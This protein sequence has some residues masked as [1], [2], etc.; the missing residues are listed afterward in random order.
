LGNFGEGKG[1]STLSICTVCQDE[2]EPIRWYLECCKRLY[3]DLGDSL[4]EVVLVDGGSKDNTIDVIN[5]YK[6]TIPIK[7]LERPWDYTVAQTNYGLSFCTGDFTFL[8]DADMTWTSNFADV[9]KSGK[10]S[11]SPYWDFRLL[12]TAIDANHYFTWSGG[13]TTRLTKGGIKCKTD[14]KYHW[15]L[16]GRVGGVP[17]CE[18][19]YMFENSC[20]ITNYDALMNR[21]IRRQVCNDDMLAEG[22][23]PGPPDRFYNAAHDLS[24]AVPIPEH[25]RRFV[26]Q[27]TNP[28]GKG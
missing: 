1:M 25:I 13:P 11:G 18:E 6:D 16:E 23:P 10:F 3:E 9:F 17:V 2:E 19:V 7:L 28:K 5:S 26:L 12:F 14:R 27:S 4:R 8:P 24:S 21:G 15:S 20:R 22:A